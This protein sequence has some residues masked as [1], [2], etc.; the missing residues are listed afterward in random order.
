MYVVLLTVHSWLRWALILVTLA[1]AGFATRR[2]CRTAPWTDGS[3][4]LARVWVSL[5]DLQVLVGMTLY[6]AY[7]PIAR[8]ARAS[9][10]WALRN[11][12]LRFFGLLHPIAMAL[13]FVVTHATW[14]AVRRER[15]ARVRYR[16]WALGASGSLVLLSLAIPWPQ[17]SYG[18][19]LFRSAALLFG[20]AT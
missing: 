10:S 9:P 14:I 12:S 17:T 18:R 3:S 4:R 15:E 8:L 11:P 16:R 2:L 7:S 6:F 20:G 1:S 5:V 13:V 19:P